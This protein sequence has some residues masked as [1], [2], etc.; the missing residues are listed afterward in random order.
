M[1]KQRKVVAKVIVNKKKFVISDMNHSEEKNILN[2]SEEKEPQPY[3]VEKITKGV[4]DNGWEIATASG[5]IEKIA[6]TLVKYTVF[7]E[8]QR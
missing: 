2:E 6:I 1:K 4:F 8:K 7:P 5:F 3:Q